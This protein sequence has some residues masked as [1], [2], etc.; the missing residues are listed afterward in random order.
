MTDVAQE[1]GIWLAKGL[2]A[3]AGALIS[4]VYL[5]PK[6]RREAAGRFFIGMASGV[7]F[8]GATGVA[9]SDWLAIGERLTTLEI[10]LMGSAAASLCAWWALGVLAR[11]AERWSE[12]RR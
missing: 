10:T 6:G 5:L 1:F 2:G 4:L 9:L 3:M 11:M 12:A 8:G 7:I